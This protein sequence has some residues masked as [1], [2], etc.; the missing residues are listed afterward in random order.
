MM[1]LAGG[2]TKVTPIASTMTVGSQSYTFILTNYYVDG[3]VSAASPLISFG[4]SASGSMTAPG[5]SVGLYWQSQTN[6]TSAG[7]VWVEVSGNRPVGYVSSVLS[8]SVSLGTVTYS[9]YNALFD[10]TIFTVG[11]ASVTNPFGTSGTKTIAIS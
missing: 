10:V 6:H 3:W 9:S 2:K 4:A 7:Q 11:A 8:N 1:L 5:E